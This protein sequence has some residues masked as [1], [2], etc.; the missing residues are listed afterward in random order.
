MTGFYK[1]SPDKI[2]MNIAICDNDK[3]I[4]QK[5]FD[6]IKK[7][8]LDAEIFIF[9]SK[10]NLLKSKKN[11]S[12]YF[13]DIKGVDGLEIAKILRMRENFSGFKSILI[14]ITGYENFAIEA[15]DVHAFYYLLKPIDSKKFSQILNRAVNEL[16]FFENISEK[17]LLAKIDGMNKKI[18][19]K[20]IF[21]IESANKKVIV[22][23]SD[24]NFEIYNKMDALEISLGENFFRCHR[25]FI[26]NFEKISAY[27]SENIELINGE[28]I[29]I[30]EKRYSDFVKKFLR[31]AKNGGVVNVY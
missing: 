23:T 11:F 29:F 31:Y 21:Y 16:K 25:F 30:A 10:E 2:S 22:H 17:F 24:K 26:V 28:K 5:I 27:D 9:N 18:F 6:L 1:N 8:N 4:C 14:F 3:K 12:I 19:L 7:E 15:F 20:D 13:L